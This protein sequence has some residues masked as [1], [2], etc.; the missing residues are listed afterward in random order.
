VTTHPAQD[1]ASDAA[2]RRRPR[3]MYSLTSA[4]EPDIEPIWSHAESV[5]RPKR[6]PREA[7]TADVQQS[8]YLT[9]SGSLIQLNAIVAAIQGL[10]LSFNVDAALRSAAAGALSLHVLAAFVLCW[11]ARPTLEPPNTVRDV[12]FV[13]GHKHAADTFSNYRRGWRMTLLALTASS[14]A[15]AMFVLNSFGVA[16]SDLASS[17]LAAI[18]SR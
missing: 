14:L 3:V 10:L 15:A 11:A 5:D 4:R 1:P 7:A 17:W 2:S 6:R 13:D 18:Q 9:A 12:S 8:A 16:A